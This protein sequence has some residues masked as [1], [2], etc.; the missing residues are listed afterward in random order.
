MG[1]GEQSDP[2]PCGPQDRCNHGRYRS[3]TVSAG[4]MDA[5]ELCMRVAGQGKD[6]SCLVESEFNAV[7]L[8]A[9]KI[10][11]RS[12][13]AHGRVTSWDSGM[14]CSISLY[15]LLFSSRLSTTRSIIP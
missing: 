6:L 13:V 11:D 15:T 8:E 12:T 14:K 4:Y 3:L 10:V 7:L 2:E 1:R 5:F 9:I